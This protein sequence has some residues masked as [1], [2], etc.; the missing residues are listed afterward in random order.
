V[1]RTE[2]VTVELVD[3]LDGSA[4]SETIAFSID[5]KAYEIDL[6]KRNAAAMRRAFK[7]YADAGR[8]TRGNRRTVGRRASSSRAG[9]KTLFSQL[10]VE[11]KERF[12]KWGVRRKLTTKTARRIADSA[13]QSWIDA[14]RP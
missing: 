4:A 12:R 1:A 7:K 2:I 5:G 3:D 8:A 11:E 6:S 9:G 14:G 13:V 10:D